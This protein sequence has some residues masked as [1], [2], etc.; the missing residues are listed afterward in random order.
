MN[1]APLDQLQVSLERHINKWMEFQ[2]GKDG[3]WAA[4]GYVGDNIARLMAT[5]AMSVLRATT[6]LNQYYERED[7]LK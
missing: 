7:L 6:E 1:E 5:A 3:A 4:V 2:A